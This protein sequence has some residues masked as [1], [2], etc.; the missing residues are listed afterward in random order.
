MLD[1]MANQPGTYCLLFH[2]RQAASVQV[3]RLGRLDI[4]CGYYF[5]IGSA[6][7]PGGV[8]ARVRHHAA[9]SHR[10]HWHLDYIRPALHLQTVW[11]SIDSTRYEHRWADNLRH[12]LSLTIPLIG[13]GASD[14]A[15][16]SHFFYTRMCP[17]GSS[18]L[19]ALT[20]HNKNMNIRFVD[21]I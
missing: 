18:I 17:P 16:D 19:N 3:G 20:R 15:C 2:A 11:Y 14:C 7:G 1:E 9:I 8:R 21:Q 13:L 10:P 6:F 5:Y 12:T 4:E